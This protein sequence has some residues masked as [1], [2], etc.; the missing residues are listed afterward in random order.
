MIPARFEPLAFGFV[1]S[2]LMSFVVSG[3]STF[4][5]TG[6]IE[7]FLGLWM[8]AWPT[9]WLVALPLVLGAAP[10][11]RRIAHRLVKS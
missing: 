8:G 11:A 5:T 3:I 9:S 1:L 6:L 10:L 2:G 7:G 4:R